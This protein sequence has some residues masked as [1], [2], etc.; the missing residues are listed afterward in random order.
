MRF[1][2]EDYTVNMAYCRKA[3]S[4][5]G[6]LCFQHGAVIHSHGHA[7]RADGIQIFP[8]R[9]EGD[10]FTCVRQ[11]CAYKSADGACADDTEFHA[12]P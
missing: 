6:A 10:I 12:S 5:L 1:Q 11:F 3:V 7:A 4:G 9:D 2:R 8:A